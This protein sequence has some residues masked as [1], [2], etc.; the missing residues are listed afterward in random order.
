MALQSLRSWNQSRP[1]RLKD[2]VVVIVG[3]SS[4]I[5]RET[6]LLFGRNKASVVLAARSETAL[7]QVAAEI[8]RLGGRAK[9]V[10]TEVSRY[11]DLERLAQEAANW[12]GKVDTWINDAGISEYG[13]FEDM[14]EEEIDRI[15]QVNLLGQLYGCKAILPIMRQQH[16]G[17]I[18]NVGSIVSARA[19]PLQSVYS[20]TKFGIRGFTDALRLEQAHIRSGI[21]VTL[22]MPASTN[23]PLFR[24]ARSK[25]GR[26]PKPLPPVY[27]VS[28]VA[29][30]IVYA[31]Q[32][33]RRTV[34]IGGAGK[35][36]EV[37]ERISPAVADWWMLR[38]GWAFRE[39]FSNEPASGHD[40]MFEKEDAVGTSHGEFGARTKKSSMY[41]PLELHPAITTALCGAALATAAAW[42]V[43]RQPTQNNRKRK[44]W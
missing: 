33:P 3:A 40:T 16:F 39:Q 43:N 12:Q 32:H 11:D 27:D 44:L 36:L 22:I 10:V 21:N 23:T 8:E 42:L 19:I 41:T 9:C 38:N 20:A 26:K 28:I 6:A 7:E 15:V 37:L 4:G 34:I 5:G 1:R 2:Q 35:L 13:L 25:N 29:R 17:A 14:A 31:A 18:L 30:A 24:H